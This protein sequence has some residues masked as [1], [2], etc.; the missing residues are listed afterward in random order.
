MVLWKEQAYLDEIDR[1]RLDS[2]CYEKCPRNPFLDL[3][4]GIIYCLSRAFEVGLLIKREYEYLK[5]NEYNIPTF[6]ITPKVHKNMKKLP[7]CP[8]VSGMGGPLE[9]VGKYI[10]KHI[11]HL[12]TE[13][14]SFVLDS[15]DILRKLKDLIIPEDCVLAGVDVESLYSSIPHETGVHVVSQW[16]EAGH[17]LAGPYNEF[18]LELL[19]MVLNNNC[20][21]FNKKF[22]CQ[23]RGVAMGAACAP[24]Y[25]CLHLGWW[26]KEDVYTHPAFDQFVT[27]WVCYIDDVLVVW[28][29]SPEQFEK[30]ILD[31]NKG[32]KNIFLT[33]NMDSFKI[34]FLDLMISKK[35]NRIAT[36]TFRKPTAGDTLLHATS[37]HPWP[38]IFRARGYQLYN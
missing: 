31:L 19:E 28:R 36:T 17:P 25:A 13:L 34:E 30:F 7:G 5:V 14:P 12:V 4:D 37:H 29:G 32:N 38:L 26:E 21:M 6:Y 1:Q 11:K 15:S 35:G 18:L 20:F 2:S 9:R 8:I 22:F 33:Y 23:I 10:D 27:L 3:V 16:L 24:S